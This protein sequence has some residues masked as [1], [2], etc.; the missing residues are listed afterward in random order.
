MTW[1]VV[2]R[3]DG[4]GSGVADAEADGALEHPATRSTSV[5]VSVRNR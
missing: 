5:R 1:K 3:P 2:N 4:E